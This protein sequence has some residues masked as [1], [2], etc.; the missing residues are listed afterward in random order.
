[1]S[2]LKGKIVVIAKLSQLYSFFLGYLYSFYYVDFVSFFFNV[3]TFIFIWSLGMPKYIINFMYPLM[4]KNMLSIHIT[5]EY[6]ASKKDKL[7]RIKS[8][9]NYISFLLL[10]RKVNYI[11]FF[12]NI[13]FFLMQKRNCFLSLFIFITYHFNQLSFNQYIFINKFFSL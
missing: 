11:P 13:Y 3:T 2:Y 5:D 10:E 9:I 1:M 12:R 6:N 8:K 4:H 7:T